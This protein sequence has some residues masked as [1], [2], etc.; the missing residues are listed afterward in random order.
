MCCAQTVTRK[1][2]LISRCLGTELLTCIPSKHATALTCLGSIAVN[3]CVLSRDHQDVGWDYEDVFIWLKRE[4][5]LV[6]LLCGPSQAAGAHSQVSTALLPSKPLLLPAALP[7]PPPSPPSRAPTTSCHSP[8]P[9]GHTGMALHQALLN[10]WTD[11][12]LELC[13]PPG[14]RKPVCLL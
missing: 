12:F 1:K 14:H 11:L 10:A 8:A 4:T 7:F 5:L 6:F 2:S 9:G 13:L 3:H